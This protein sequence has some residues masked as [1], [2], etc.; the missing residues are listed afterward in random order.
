MHL[1]EFFLLYFP[2]PVDLVSLG[3]HFSQDSSL[4]WSFPQSWGHKW[5]TVVLEKETADHLDP[6]M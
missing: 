5:V 4:V 1:S 2:A 3:E 6:K